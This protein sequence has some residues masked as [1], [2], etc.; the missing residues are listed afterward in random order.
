MRIRYTTSA[1]DELREALDYLAERSP[2]GARNV[3]VSIQ[4]ALERVLIWPAAGQATSD[5]NLRRMLATPYPYFV[6]YEP[7]ETEIIVHRVRHTSR[8]PEEGGGTPA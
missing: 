4:R 1:A 5:P 8:S 3:A 7:T 2:Q 6:L